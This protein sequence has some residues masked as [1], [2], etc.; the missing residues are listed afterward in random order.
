M[1][2]PVLSTI[3]IGLVGSAIQEPIEGPCWRALVEVA[4][5]RRTEFEIA[6]CFREFER[7]ESASK[8]KRA[9]GRLTVAGVR[10]SSSVVS[11]SSA[12]VHYVSALDSISFK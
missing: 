5:A 4:A 6:C 9:C 7:V 2:L 12:L 10:T 11:P 3:A 1:F 8:C